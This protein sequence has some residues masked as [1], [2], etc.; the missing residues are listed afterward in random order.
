MYLMLVLKANGS[1][2]AASFYDDLFIMYAY[3]FERLLTSVLLL[4][5][6]VIN[7]DLIFDFF[8]DLRNKD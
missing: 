2:L 7:P 8:H 4:L 5:Q 6:Y 3:K 1:Q